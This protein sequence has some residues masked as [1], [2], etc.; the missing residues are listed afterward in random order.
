M[1]AQPK[2]QKPQG[3][4]KRLPNVKEPWWCEE[5]TQLLNSKNEAMMKFH[6]SGTDEDFKTYMEALK[7]YECGVKDLKFEWKEKRRNKKKDTNAS[8]N[9]QYVEYISKPWW[10]EEATQL[11]NSMKE[12][13]EKYNKSGNIDDLR[14][15][16]KA[17]NAFRKCKN[18]LKWEWKQQQRQQQY[19]GQTNMENTANQEESKENQGGEGNT[20]NV[21]NHLENSSDNEEKENNQKDNVNETNKNNGKPKR[22]VKGN[23]RDTSEN[24]YV[25]KPWWCEEVEHLMNCRNKA[26]HQYYKTSS[27]VDLKAYADAENALKACINKKKRA[28]KRIEESEPE[29][30][31]EF[32]PKPWW[33]E[34]ATRLVECRNEA[35]SKYNKS[36]TSEDLKAYE[37]AEEIFKTYINQLKLDWKQKQRNDK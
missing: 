4:K 22:S 23:M 16:K 32:V 15:Y 35:R 36:K 2:T 17:G 24:R 21:N 5:A 20:T 27:F 13:K 33:C 30:K 19:Q 6:M 31:L 3:N 37:E 12:A 25:P 8:Y 1:E 26:R 14:E 7:A 28:W 11:F 10:C 29:P 9:T 34:E 18:E